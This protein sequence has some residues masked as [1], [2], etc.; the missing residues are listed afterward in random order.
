MDN[1]LEEGYERKS[2]ITCVMFL[3]VKAEKKQNTMIQM[4]HLTGDFFALAA[5]HAAPIPVFSKNLS[6]WD[7]S[8]LNIG[9]ASN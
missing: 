6:H 7:D 4:V 3:I 5:L 1:E 9:V 2:S 8:P